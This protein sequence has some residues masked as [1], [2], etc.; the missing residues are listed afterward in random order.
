MFRADL[1]QKRETFVAELVASGR[2]KSKSQV[3]REG[4]RLIQERETR[5]AVLDLALARGLADLREGRTK[6]LARR[7][8]AARDQVDGHW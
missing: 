4:I 2:H 1:G 5:L 7:D 8:R 6:P 3:L